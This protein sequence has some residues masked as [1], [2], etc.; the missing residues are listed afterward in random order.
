MKNL[1][2]ILTGCIFFLF[3]GCSP[4]KLQLTI[5]ETQS[6]ANIPSGSGLQKAGTGYYVVGDDAPF[7]YCLDS[8]FKVTS[9]I[10]LVDTLSF[11]AGR[12]EKS[13]KP[14]F[15]AMEQVGENELVIFGSGSKSPQRDLFVR[16]LLEDSPRVEKHSL[17]PFYRQLKS[18]PAFKD[19]ELN[20]EAVAHHNGQLFLFN[21]NP[22]LLVRFNY[23]TF[24]NYLKGTAPLPALHVTP[25]SLPKI[26]GVEAGFSGATILPA[27][28]KIIFTATAEATQNA[29]AD[30][31]I[32]GSIVGLI[33]LTDGAV[34]AT[35]EY[36]L[37]STE[38]NPLK[39]ESVTVEEVPAGREAK[40]VFVTDDDRGNSVI[41]KGVLNW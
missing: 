18:L 39:V 2:Q 26:R 35:F 19:S 25:F 34:A 10:P 36:T 24:L 12:M 8:S 23:S 27:E 14:D 17:T 3:A 11:A 28:S 32:R 41:L 40:L 4:A 22:A 5:T 20:I 15:E 21:R 13:E 29:Y 33:N 31:E 9:K 38:G 7:L 1:I 6:L 30:G 16:V 37:I